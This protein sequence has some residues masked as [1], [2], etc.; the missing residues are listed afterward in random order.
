MIQNIKFKE[1][2]LIK[3]CEK[4]KVKSLFMFGSAVNGNFNENSDLDFL[5]HFKADVPLLDFADN[6]FS[7][8]EELGK[9]FHKEIDLLTS[10]S[11]KNPVLSR[12]IENTKVLL[13][14]A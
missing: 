5:V 14:A 1:E 8:M 10:E 13:Y 2:E 9:L 11:V 3:L 12:E 7:L 6:F 4:H